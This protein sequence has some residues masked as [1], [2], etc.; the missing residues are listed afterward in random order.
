MSIL[1][2]IVGQL[3]SGGSSSNVMTDYMDGMYIADYTLPPNSVFTVQKEWNPNCG[4]YGCLKIDGTTNVS[5]KIN[6]VVPSDVA[7]ETG[8]FKSAMVQ[9][10]DPLCTYVLAIKSG[11]PDGSPETYSGTMKI[12]EIKIDGKSYP[13]ETIEFTNTYPMA[14]DMLMT[15][16]AVKQ[17]IDAVNS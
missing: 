3:E 12:T 9:V 8:D 4:C 13:D 5:M 14:S 16:K 2:K 17:Y 10:A 15:A 11:I 7:T 1:G 6:G